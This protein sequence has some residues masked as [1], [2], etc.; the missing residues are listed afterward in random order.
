VWQVIGGVVGESLEMRDME[1]ALAS[2]VGLPL[3][4]VVAAIM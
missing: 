2:F 3:G 1:R 4:F